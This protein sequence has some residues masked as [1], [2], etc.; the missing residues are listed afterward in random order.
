MGF[1][2]NLLQYKSLIQSDCYTVSYTP[3][4]KRAMKLTESVIGE[5]V[6]IKP[7]RISQTTHCLTESSQ[8]THWT[9]G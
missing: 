2:P 9:A 3:Q 8:T 6:W 4:F 7:K 5:S 1:D